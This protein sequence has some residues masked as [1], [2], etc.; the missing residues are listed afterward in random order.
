[1]GGG[2]SI[3]QTNPANNFAALFPT[4]SDDIKQSSPYFQSQQNQAHNTIQPPNQSNS[5]HPSQNQPN[6]MFNASQQQQQQQ[7]NQPNLTAWFSMAPLKPQA[8]PNF[9]QQQVPAS[10]PMTVQQPNQ[11]QQ[12]DFLRPMQPVTQAASAPVQ[13]NRDRYDVFREIDNSGPS[14]FDSSKTSKPPQQQQ[15]APVQQDQGGV[16]GAQ[17]NS[18]LP[19]YS[20]GLNGNMQ[21]NGNMQPN[22]TSNFGANGSMSTQFPNQKAQSQPQPQSNIAAAPGY[23]GFSGP[24]PAA[25]PFGNAASNNPNDMFSQFNPLL[26]QNLQNQNNKNNMPAG[27]AATGFPSNQSPAMNTP[28]SNFTVNPNGGLPGGFQQPAP[29]VQMPPQNAPNNLAIDNS[30]NPF[31]PFLSN[32]GNQAPQQVPDIGINPFLSP[33]FLGPGQNAPMDPS[34]VPK[35]QPNTDNPFGSSLTNPFGSQVPQVNPFLGSNQPAQ[36][37]QQNQNGFNNLNASPFF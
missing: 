37:F 27:F 1:M 28:N 31:N 19:G 36:S 25:N 14:I 24:A 4:A 26:G 3:P 16:F 9:M 29:P 21:Q 22:F 6:I 8:S 34:V 2:F 13:N 33:F 12:S 10:A 11:R 20:G 18:G 32:N 35:Q 17:Y 30:Y 5:F 7:F 23:Q 15:Q